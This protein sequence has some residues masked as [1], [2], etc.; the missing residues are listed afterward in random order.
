MD[1]TSNDLICNTNLTHFSD[2]I[3]PV[4]AGSTIQAE[5][6]HE[7][8]E[9]P[10]GNP[11]KPDPDDPIAASHHGPIVTYLLARHLTSTV[12]SYLRLTSLMI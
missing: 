7:I 12:I 4:Q 9:Q 11:G 6:R 10:G 1:V 5:W 2:V 3:L 8:G